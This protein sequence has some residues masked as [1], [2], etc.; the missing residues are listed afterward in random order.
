MSTR[1]LRQPSPD[2]EAHTLATK[3]GL[4]ESLPQNPEQVWINRDIINLIIAIESRV[5]AAKNP[6]NQ[7]RPIMLPLITIAQSDSGE[8][9]A[10]IT[11]KILTEL[12]VDF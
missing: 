7:A 2:Q 8:L 5:K 10:I 3:L 4:I 6:D 11:R 1:K 12:G 9:N